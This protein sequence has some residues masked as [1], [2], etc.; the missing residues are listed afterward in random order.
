MTEPHS[1]QLPEKIQKAITDIYNK[2]SPETLFIYGSHAR[3]DYTPES[4][5]EVGLL[6][7]RECRIKRDNLAQMHSIPNLHLYSFP[8]EEF[9]Q[10][11][12]QIPFTKAIYFNELLEKGAITLMGKQIL[13]KMIPPQIVLT[14]ILEELSF[15]KARALSAM[16]SFRQNDIFSAT[17]HLIKSCLYATKMLFL[18]EKGLFVSRY[19]EILENIKTIPIGPSYL[20]LIEYALKL[21][22]K[23]EIADL[24]RIHENLTY[25][26]YVFQK[27]ETKY[28]SE[29]DIQ[30]V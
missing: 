14:D 16:L 12:I 5:Y 19:D 30:L 4:D 29:G 27:A 21:R 18:L 7:K 13:E 25:I 8:F 17:D 23:R 1:M 2:T 22:G 15:D 24:K 6:Y 3:G 9:I 10:L 28:K 11:D 26:E 20:L